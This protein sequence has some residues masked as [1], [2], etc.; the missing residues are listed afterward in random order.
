MAADVLCMWSAEAAQEQCWPG[1]VGQPLV[2]A[3]QRRLLEAAVLMGMPGIGDDLRCSMLCTGVPHQ[4][5]REKGPQH[6]MLQA[7]DEQHAPC[8]QANPVSMLPD[9][10]RCTVALSLRRTECCDAEGSAE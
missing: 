3:K 9:Q 5:N 6:F 8:C 2:V 7:A 4:S 10:C 1:A